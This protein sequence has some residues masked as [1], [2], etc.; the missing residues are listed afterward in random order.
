M[1][2]CMYVRTYVRN[3]MYVCMTDTDT[4]R[5]KDN[6]K[7]AQKQKQRDMHFRTLN[8]DQEHFEL[9]VLF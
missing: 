1:Y 9:Y 6:S 2:V 4:D 8:M 7:L 5:D 3:T